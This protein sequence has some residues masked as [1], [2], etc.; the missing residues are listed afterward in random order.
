M[1]EDAGP[2]DTPVGVTIDSYGVITVAEDAQ[3]QENNDI[4]V[5]ATY[6]GRDYMAIFTVSKAIAGKTPII[7]QFDNQNRM[8]P[9]DPDGNPKP[10]QLPVAIQATLYRGLAPLA[11]GVQWGLA[12]TPAGISINQNGLI[13]VTAITAASNEYTVLAVWRGETFTA[14]LRITK[15]NDGAVG[16]LGPQGDPAP[17]YLGKTL[18]PGGNTG[19]VVIQIGTTT[20]T[21]QAHT[22]DW[23]AYV[24]ETAGLWA[25]GMCMRWNGGAW[26]QV[27]PTAEPALY[28]EALMDLTEGAPNGVFTSIFCRVI[29]AQ[30]ALIDTI[31]ARV[32]TMTG[33][34]VIQSEGFTGV[35]GDVPGFML[36]ARDGRIEA[37]NGIFKNLTAVTT[38]T[39]DIVSGGKGYL[40]IGFVYL[41]LR[42]Q[43][44]P[45]TL[46]VGTWENISHQ[47]SGLFFRVS[48][49]NAA[50]FGQDQ[51][52]NIQSHNHSYTKNN[53]AA[54]WYDSGNQGR[55]ALWGD[56]KNGSS[57]TGNTGGNETRP[58]NSTIQI[59][60]RTA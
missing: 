35:D 59:W 43:P 33:D 6:Q 39:F 24:G 11:E 17:H 49:G 52:M 7:L 57:S 8:I 25:K 23:V 44:D 28:M 5:I 18:T 47:Y 38:N 21:V 14:I 29:G 1:E 20:Q 3:L 10:G 46:F 32:L 54:L 58:V 12:G 60:K 45:N 41:Q 34:G 50:A 56:L 15:S 53:F 19:L 51:G 36:R 40:P 2:G 26:E 4:K 48:G 13:T 42:G 22:G 27:S 37:N 9:C 16:P 31:M 55:S 30:Q